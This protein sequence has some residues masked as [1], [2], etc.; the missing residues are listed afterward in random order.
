MSLY[1]F[2]IQY[3]TLPYLIPGFASPIPAASTESIGY[4]SSAVALRNLA[5]AGVTVMAHGAPHAL[6]RQKVVAGSSL[7]WAS[8]HTPTTVAHAT[9]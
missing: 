7:L 4:T 6:R 2:E 8:P 5:P 1:V 9:L 3:L